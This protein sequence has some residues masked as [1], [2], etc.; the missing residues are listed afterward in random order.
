MDPRD[1]AALACAVLT[2]PG[3]AGQIYDVTGPE[4]LSARE[5]VGILSRVVGKHIRYVRI[6]LF[7]AA[8]AMRRFGA[9]REL[10]D[11][12]K[13]TFGAWERNEYAYVS[14]AVE[15]VTGRKPRS[16]EGLVPRSPL[17]LYGVS[18]TSCGGLGSRAMSQWTPIDSRRAAA[19]RAHRSE[20]QAP[21]E[22]NPF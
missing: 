2:Q 8:I 3:H 16:F 10:T 13:E 21:S 4:P 6:P 19:P 14:D 5:M 12:I 11:A 7:V 17:I 15:G 1:I 22:P 9:T 18:V 20:K